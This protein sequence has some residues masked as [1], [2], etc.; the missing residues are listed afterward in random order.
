MTKDDEK[1]RQTIVRTIRQ[2]LSQRGVGLSRLIL[3]GS[4]ARGEARPDSDWDIL[5]V[6]DTPLS[7]K[8]ISDFRLSIA[9]TLAKQ[10][11]D[12]EPIVYDEQTLRQREGDVGEIVHYA[13]KE[14]VA[15]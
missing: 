2:A 4:R 6:T 3:F 5:V 14:G 1:T 8:A 11:I 9:R 10:M 7:R 15:I 12:I 13:M